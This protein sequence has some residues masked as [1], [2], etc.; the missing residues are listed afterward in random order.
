MSPDEIRAVQAAKAINKFREEKS[1]ASFNLAEL[2]TALKTNGCPYVTCIVTILRKKL[3]IT[4][5]EKRGLYI[6]SVS[7]P[8]AYKTILY[9]LSQSAKVFHGYVQS[10]KIRHKEAKK[11]AENERTENEQIEFM[12]K[13]LKEK[14]YRIQKPVI[15]YEDV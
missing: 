13:T 7:Q 6:F 10:Y 15:N 1:T 5:A 8:V 2:Q 14:G 3:I 12:I 9:D 4:Q 11:N